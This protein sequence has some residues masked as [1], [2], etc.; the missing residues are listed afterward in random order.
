[1]NS[2]HY[3]SAIQ[4]AEAVLH[5]SGNNE[6]ALSHKAA[7]LYGLRRFRD[8]ANQLTKVS[9][10]NPKDEE[11]TGNFRRCLERLRE[12]K[13]H[14]DFAA[15]LDEAIAKNPNA[16]MDRADY[17][18]PIEVRTCADKSHGRGI[19]SIKPIKVGEL[20]LVEKAFCATFPPRSKSSGKY[21]TATGLSNKSTLS[22]LQA[23]LAAGIFVKLHRNP[24]QVPAFAA[25]YPG[26][27]NAGAAIDE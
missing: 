5:L 23:K 21:D 20:L 6:M 13:G 1:M 4:D 10:L 16:E 11:N 2:Q 24:S 7:A 14:Y 3:D 26:P 18:G 9:K 8:C 27:N 15:M 17:V 25:L 12:E 19:F 22:E